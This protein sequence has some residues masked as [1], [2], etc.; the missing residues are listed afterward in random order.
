MNGIGNMKIGNMNM[1]FVDR[2]RV[3]PRNVIDLDNMLVCCNFGGSAQE[4]D[5]ERLISM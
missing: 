3:E 5:P 1:E 4:L 2:R